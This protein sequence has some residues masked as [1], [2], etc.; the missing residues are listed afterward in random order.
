MYRGYFNTGEG[1]KLVAIKTCKRKFYVV[2]S[3]HLIY[4]TYDNYSK[5]LARMVGQI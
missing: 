3:G 4:D 1:K 2:L 5:N